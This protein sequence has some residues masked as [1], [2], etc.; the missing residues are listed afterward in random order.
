MENRRGLYGGWRTGALLIAVVM[1]ASLLTATPATAH[2][3]APGDINGDGYRDAVL[4]TPGANVAGMSG[5][6]MITASSVGLPQRENTQFRGTA[7]LG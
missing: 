6:R 3:A 4:P 5:A 1:G 2:G 7:L